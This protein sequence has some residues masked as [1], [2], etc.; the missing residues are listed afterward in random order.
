MSIHDQN[1]IKTI[2]ISKSFPRFHKRAP[3]PKFRE[4]G[5]EIQYFFSQIKK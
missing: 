2:I 1:Y 3:Y 4:Y 5:T